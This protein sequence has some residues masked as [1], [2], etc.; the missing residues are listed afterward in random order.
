M[1]PVGKLFRMSQKDNADWLGVVQ[2]NTHQRRGWFQ[3]SRLLGVE[4]LP[5]G[6]ALDWSGEVWSLS[7]AGGVPGRRIVTADIPLRDLYPGLGVDRALGLWAALQ[8]WGSPVLVVDAGTALTFT[9]GVGE[10]FVGGAI[11]P[12]WR[13][14]ARALH[15]LTAALPEISLGGSLPPRWATDTATA[16]DSGITYGLR[17]TIEDFAQAWREQYPTATIV[18]TGGDAE[19]LGTD[20]G[21]VQPDLLLQGI[22]LLRAQGIADLR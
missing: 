1:L 22:S 20:L 7:V 17:A 15:Q 8:I 6:S 18:I 16:I 4:V 3:G 19:R 21:I 5:R 12:G 14:Q 13:S 9:A 11:L 2:G 10:R